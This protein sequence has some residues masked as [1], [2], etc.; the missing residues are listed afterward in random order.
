MRRRVLLLAV[1]ALCAST[2]AACGGRD[3]GGAAKNETTPVGGASGDQSEAAGTLG[4]PAF[5]TKNTTRVGGAAP[6]ADA[7]G[8]A[9]AV[10]PGASR[11]TRPQAVVLADGRDWRVGLVSSVLM[12]APLRAPLLY[13][14]GPDK[15]P[16]A[17]QSALKAL[18]PTGAK[19]AGNAQF[20]RVGEVPDLPGLRTTD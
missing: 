9:R 6:V 13:G 1:L 16:G 10:Y 7:A 15:L 3:G 2:V 20:V 14:D 12:G 18:A 4:S 19:A 5:S 8:V 17:T 11:V